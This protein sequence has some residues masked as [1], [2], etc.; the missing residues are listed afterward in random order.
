M[1]TTNHRPFTYPEGRID[2]PSHTSREGAVKYTDYAL[3]KFIKEASKTDWYANTVFVITAD[4][5]AS[6]AGKSDLPIQKYRIPMLIFS[7]NHFTPGF[8]N[9][10]MSQIDIAPTV[11]GLLHFSYHS[12][13]FGNDIFKLAKGKERAFISTYQA[14]GYLKNDSLA[15]LLPKKQSEF[16]IVNDH[17]ESIKFEKDQSQT[18]GVM[19]EAISWYQ[20]ASYSFK[21]GKLKEQD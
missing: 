6:S 3:G 4:H 16:F 13:F 7:P 5:C 21:N 10:L 20:T 9:K 11:L 17:S 1:T 2:I 19:K 15:V 12:K 14:L 8:E 18:N